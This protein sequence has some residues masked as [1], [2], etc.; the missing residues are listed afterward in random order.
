MVKKN[1]H[2]DLKEKIYMTQPNNY[3]EKGKEILVCK[4][5]RSLYGLKQSLRMWC[6]ILDSFEMRLGIL[7]SEWDHYVYYKQGDHFLD[8]TLYVD[9]ILF[10]GNSKNV[11]CDL[12]SYLVA[13]FYMNSYGNTKYNLRI[14]KE[15]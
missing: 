7:R 8:I 4:L 10:F 3:F 13:Q 9:D 12:K 6:Q 15:T 14:D 11:L 5:K 2:D 1:L